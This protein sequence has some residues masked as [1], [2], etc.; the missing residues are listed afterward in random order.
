LS[1][2]KLM[3]LGQSIPVRFG[4]LQSLLKAAGVSASYQAPVRTKDGIIG[5][6]LTL[7]TTLPGTPGTPPLPYCPP[8]P[9]PCG[10]PLT[11]NSGVLVTLGSSSASV[12]YTA[13]DDYPM[14]TSGP[15][16]PGAAGAPPASGHGGGTP[17]ASLAP[18]SERTPDPGPAPSTGGQPGPASRIGTASAQLPD[19]QDLYLAIVVAALT[20]LAS[21]QAVRI[22]G[23]RCAWN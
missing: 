18:Q 7:Q 17:P 15:T 13:F 2:G 20:A 9:V 4:Q 16:A 5:A 14:P 11:D 22:M 8:N 10:N 21:A 6:N 23:A 19:V 12:G 1:D 3:L